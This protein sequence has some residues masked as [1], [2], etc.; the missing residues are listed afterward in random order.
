MKCGFICER[1]ACDSMLAIFLL[2]SV[3]RVSRALMFF[4]RVKKI[5]LTISEPASTMSTRNHQ[6]FQKGRSIVNV[7]EAGVRFH[8][9]SLLELR[10]LKVYF[11]SGRL[12]YLAIRSLDGGDHLVSK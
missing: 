6:V 4:I 8:T 5:A 12:E 11:P 1:N 3:F 10:T 9:P 2:S 7:K